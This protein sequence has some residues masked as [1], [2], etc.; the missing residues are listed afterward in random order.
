M[1]K[2]QLLCKINNQKT[3]LF[4]TG[5]MDKMISR[6]YPMSNYWYGYCPNGVESRFELLVFDRQHQPFLPLTE[7]Y[8]DCIGRISKSSALSY[9]RCLLPFFTWLEQYSNYQGENVRWDNPPDILRIAVEDYLMN[10]MACKVREKD[11][12]RF[13]NRTNK[14]PN[15]VNRFL[16][17][18]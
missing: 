17:A 2:K 4:I 15:T 18:L 10:E 5:S 6:C 1:N 3:F 11:T 7:Y 12:F 13:V 16:S 9:I 8:H 14:S